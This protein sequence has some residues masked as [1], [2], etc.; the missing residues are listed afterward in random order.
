MQFSVSQESLSHLLYLT[1]T[2]VE[3]KTTMP[4]LAHV[5]LVANGN[6]LA[7]L[8]TDLEIS[9][10]GEIDAEVKSNGSITVSAKVL[11]DVVKELP[12]GN[13]T[14]VLGKQN[15]LEI[16]T[17]QSKFK[18]NGV[19]SDEF[20]TING[21]ELTSPI[22]VDAGK[23]FEMLDKTSYCVSQDETRYNINGVYVESLEEGSKDILRFV[24]T[25]GH[26]LS[27]VDRPAEGLKPTQNVIIPKK[28]ITELKKLLEKEEGVANVS[29]SQG[30]FTVQTERTTM[31]IRLVDGQFPDYR[32]VLPKETKTTVLVNRQEFLSAVKR[33]SLVT[34]DK[35]KTIKFRLLSGN[36][37][38]SSS[39]PEFGEATESIEVKQTGEDVTMGFSARY[40]LELL[41][42]MPLSSEIIVRLSGDVGP[43]LFQGTEDELYSCIVMPM[44]FE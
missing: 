34:T 11:Y 26:R 42:S 18:I 27:M 35:S 25:D 16:E 32:Q 28:G 29:I 21:I 36:L 37:T 10:R 13:L 33:V 3:K 44:R 17:A 43:G 31:G 7:V 19:S 4:I 20:P 41:N 15:R 2:I 23:L 9:L 5:N 14:V 6:S 8:A 38:V 12:P 1:S 22:A 40:I 30:F 24:A 39:S